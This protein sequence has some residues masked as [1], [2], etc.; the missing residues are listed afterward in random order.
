MQRSVALI[1]GAGP[2]LGRELALL[3]GH[4]GY[5]LVL[6]ARTE[7]SLSETATLVEADTGMRAV[8]VPA[9]V[10][11]PVGVDRVVASALSEF[12]RI[13]MGVH[14]LL[15]ASHVGYIADLDD[16]GL[17]AWCEPVNAGVRSAVLFANRC[18]RVMVEQ[19]GG[20]IVYVTAT[21]GL[22]GAAGLSS[23]AAAKAGVHAVAQ[24]LAAELGPAGVRVNCVAPSVIDGVTSTRAADDPDAGPIIRLYV[25][26]QRGRALLG[27]LPT[28]RDVAEAVAFLGGPGAGG[29]TGQILVVDRG[30]LVR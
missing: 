6:A 15:P 20:S 8:I 2:G 11:D 10:A 9:D 19:G 22:A 1:C 23:H 13:D 26:D 17:G 5:D 25:A 24:T 28:E 29:I 30:A 18:G 21:S 4:R 27:S 12:S 14:S 16:R 7:A 3:L